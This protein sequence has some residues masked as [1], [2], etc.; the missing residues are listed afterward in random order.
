MA[1]KKYNEYSHDALRFLTQGVMQV[2]DSWELTP[3]EIITLLGLSALS[4]KRQLESFRKGD[5]VFPETT[6]ILIRVDHIIGIADGLR[7]TY[8]LN[9]Q[10]GQIW[11][12]KSHRRFNRSSPLSVMLNDISPNGLLKIRMEVDCNYAYAI[13]EAMRDQS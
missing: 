4:N 5:K 3:T 2:V 10:M 1:N 11:L 7:T 8:P 9:E 12:R 13:S 6:E